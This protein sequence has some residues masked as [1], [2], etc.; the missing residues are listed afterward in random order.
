[1]P[2]G[3][4]SRSSSASLST[5]RS[6]AICRIG[7]AGPHRFLRDLRRGRV[8]DARAERRRDR[9]AAI[10]QLACP[11]R[12]GRDAVDAL[13]YE[14]RP[15]TPQNPRGVERIPC[16]DRHHHVQLELAGFAR[17]RHRDIAAHHLITD[18]IHHLG[19]RRV[20]LARHDRRARLHRRQ[21]DLAQ[22]PPAAPCSGAAG[23]SRSCRAR[24][25]GVASRL[26]RRRR[27][28]CSAS[29]E[30]DSLAGCRSTVLC[31][32]AERR[33]D[34]GGVS[35]RCVLRPVPTAVA[36]RFNSISCA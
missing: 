32:D 34:C 11:L 5:P 33:H 6:R 18:L 26:S 27:R 20:D 15:S 23:R 2:S 21:R 30:T 28:P 29:R 12:V 13:E 1:M 16:D 4:S 22:D 17:H 14:A 3:A 9:R 31:T 36:P 25:T 10:E 19:N 8:A 35:R 7:L 24:P